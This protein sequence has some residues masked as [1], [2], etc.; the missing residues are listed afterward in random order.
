MASFVVSGSG[1][2]FVMVPLALLTFVVFIPPYADFFIGD[3][4]V[5]LDRIS[6]L[7]AR[8]WAAYELLNPFRQNWYYRPLQNLWFLVNRLLFGFNPFPFYYLQ[9][10][11]HILVMALVYRLAR[12]LRLLPLAAVGSALPF[13][14][15]GHFF[16]VVTW[17]SSIAILLVALFSLAAVSAFLS[18][19]ARPAKQWLL[20]VTLVFTVLAMLSHEEGFLVIPFLLLLWW[21]KR[22]RPARRPSRRLV[23]TFGV[24]ALLVAAYLALQLVRPNLNITLSET[25]AS[26]WSRYLSPDQLS[27]FIV[28]AVVRTTTLFG[29]LGILLDNAYVAG[30]L[31]LLAGAFWFWRGG[32]VA[33]LG[34]FWLALHLGFIYWA[35]WAYQPQFFA[36]RHLYNGLIGLH[37]ALGTLLHAFVQGPAVGRQWPVLGS[38][39]ARQA[40]TGVALLALLLLNG[41]TI[42]RMHAIWLELSAHD[43]EVRQQMQQLMPQV[44]SETHVFAHRFVSDASY[45]PATVMVWYGRPQSPPGGT[46]RQL[47]DHEGV[48]RDFYLFDYSD[49]RLVNLMPELQQHD[50]TVFIWN[51]EPVMAIVTPDGQRHPP[52]AA[53]QPG[54]VLAGPEHDRRLALLT[55]LPEDVQDGWLSLRYTVPVPDGSELRLAIRRPAEGEVAYRI[56]LTPASGPGET[57]FEKQWE[58]AD[59]TT[60]AGWQDV[61][62]PLDTYR[63][64]TVTLDFE[65]RDRERVIGGGYW[66][67]MRFVSE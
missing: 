35:L 5:Q 8:P 37:L 58:E 21:F 2:R 42:G 27:Q 14:F 44:S 36:G 6:D 49:G 62:L 46:L 56:R 17:L 54:I 31:L 16:D 57:L 40:V 43:E 48:T 63:H 51:R 18:Y 19:L 59:M 55:P 10:T 30:Y 9:I 60:G 64:Q 29:A 28:H 7:L 45:L 52:D 32:T 1:L 61:V 39:A 67:N 23:A 15:H 65:V 38:K 24:M 50:Q 26:H 20:A 22:E 12:Q 3:D 34:L 25:D 47:L 11:V 13:G 53:E 66:S 41:R 33:R 4:Y